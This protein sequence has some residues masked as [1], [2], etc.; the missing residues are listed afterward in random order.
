M[1]LLFAVVAWVFAASP[2][3]R[4]TDAEYTLLASE[5]LLQRGALDVT[6]AFRLPLDATAYPGLSANIP[7]YQH[8]EAG[9]PYQIQV[10]PRAAVA[11]DRPRVFVWYPPGSSILSAPLLLAIHL[12]SPLSPVFADGRY[13]WQGEAELQGLLAAALGAAFAV[14]AFALARLWLS[15]I[16]ALAV[17]LS[18][19]LGSMIWSTTS[20]NLWSSSWGVVLLA[21]AVYLLAR[22]WTRN[23]PIPSVWLGTFLAWSYFCRP[24]FAVHIAACGLFVLLYRRREGLRLAAVGSAWFVG[25]LFWSKHLFGTW[26]PDYYQHAQLSLAHAPMS[27]AANLLSPGR[28]IL[29]Y[30]PALFVVFAMLHR[31]RQHISQQPLLWLALGAS[32]AHL[33]LLAV[34]PVWW[35][36]FSYGPRFAVELL[37]WLVLLATLALDALA[38]SQISNAIT[39]RWQMSAICLSLVAVWIH[40]RGAYSDDTYLWNLRPIHVDVDA[41]AAVWNWRYPQFLAGLVDWPWPDPLPVLP[42]G[43]P[44]A[45]SSA[46]MSPFLLEG[47]SN[48]EPAYRWT[49]E[50]RARLAFAAAPN[51]LAQLGQAHVLSMNFAVFLEPR[52]RPPLIS[53]RLQVRLNGHEIANETL[54]N[55]GLYKRAWPIAPGALAA[56]NELELLMPDAESPLHLGVGTDERLLGLSVRNLQ[57]R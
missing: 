23:R 28:G 20:R 55:A 37:P 21:A 27:L 51:Q 19:S 39:R 49:R 46:S 52:A 12:A 11:P 3:R 41:T 40:G 6:P 32:A 10:L 22:A 45:G 9:Y 48:A 44:L 47:W 53:Q 30:V 33:L 50:R 14:L 42:I 56:R 18:G 57:L 13:N 35:G 1:A 26:L 43:V 7:P 31:F 29:I 8:G 54:T 5:Q 17:A 2:V 15:P 38:R 34:Y 4:I 24:S 16:A 25:F 36:G